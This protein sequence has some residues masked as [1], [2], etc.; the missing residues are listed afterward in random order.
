MSPSLAG[1]RTMSRGGS[2]ASRP[3]TTRT[4]SR[5][6]RRGD[7]R[8]SAQTGGLL[9]PTTFQAWTQQQPDIQAGQQVNERRPGTGTIL[10]Q[11]SSATPDIENQFPAEPMA[12]PPRICTESRTTTGSTKPPSSAHS[13]LHGPLED[14]QF[15]EVLQTEN[16]KLLEEVMFL[17]RSVVDT[18]QKKHPRFMSGGQF[19]GAP[20]K[21]TGPDPEV[22]QLRQEVRRLSGRLS[23][24]EAERLAAL[25]EAKQLR[26]QNSAAHD[27]IG[28]LE[29]QLAQLASEKDKSD[30][31]VKGLSAELAAVQKRYAEEKALWE[32]EK[33]A[34]KDAI[35]K[36][37]EANGSSDG[38]LQGSLQ[39]IAMLEEQLKVAKEQR[40][41]AEKAKA[42]LEEHVTAQAEAA[43]AAAEE[44]L[45]VITEYQTRIQEL[46]GEVT[47]LTQKCDDK[48]AQILA[49]Q[50]QLAAAQQ[51]LLDVQKQLETALA[52]LTAKQ[53]ELEE[54]LASQQGN[55]KETEALQGRIDQLEQMRR[56]LELALSQERNN[57]AKALELQTVAHKEVV[58]KLQRELD[59]A[60]KRAEAAL[61]KV[62][63]LQ[64]SLGGLVDPEELAA[65][66]RK[67]DETTAAA[68]KQRRELQGELERAKHGLTEAT[69]R[70]E[71]LQAQAKEDRAAL[72]AAKKE[73]EE[74]RKRMEAAE[75][76]AA[77]AKSQLDE[78]TQKCAKLE[79]SERKALAA[80]KTAEQ[81]AANLQTSLKAVEAEL[82][83]IVRRDRADRIQNSIQ[84][85][86]KL[87]V[88]APKVSVAIGGAGVV[89]VEGAP[90]E[91]RIRAVMMDEVLPKFVRVFAADNTNPE[92]QGV[93]SS[94]APVETYV[95]RVMAEMVNSIEE[96]LQGVFG[97]S[98]V[99]A[100]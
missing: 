69:A 77:K 100:K 99:R 64:R 32:K 28:Q 87:Q 65:L 15:A 23:T 20:S 35:D 70:A 19:R 63:D 54:A 18:M 10:P 83:K 33:A 3:G 22:A 74:M 6:G 41:A 61:A 56:D 44:H 27:R 53:K 30:A 11:L 45:R 80:Q 13:T 86:V 94:A 36:L 96:K 29:D 84:Q 88:L 31:T 39:R 55:S 91:T 25:D 60:N 95:Q 1:T 12:T 38:M 37:S 59:A 8:D 17:R 75:S 90:A 4:T 16:A 71:K 89:E 48:D 49:L 78:L 82:A 67:L 68:A 40:H 62:S 46:E 97:K 92:I 85:S 9:P 93:G 50:N 34:L 43:K 58:D 21:N 51:K 57:S 47:V 79:S 52:D 98:C 81:T 66:K 26:D 42:V 7:H 24:A 14:M 2:G 72:L 73:L 76:A 5:G